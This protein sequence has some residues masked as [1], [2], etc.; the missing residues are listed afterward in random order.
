[1]T[2]ARTGLPREPRAQALRWWLRERRLPVVGWSLVALVIIAPLVAWRAGIFDPSPIAEP[3]TSFGTDGGNL[4]ERGA[5]GPSVEIGAVGSEGD[6]TRTFIIR[7]RGAT[8]RQPAVIFLHGFGSNIVAGYEPW[9]EHLAREGITVIFPSWQQP[10]FPTDGTQNPRNNM[11]EGVRQAVEAVPIQESKVAV[12]GMSAGGALA[13]DY[14]A[15]ATKL[16]GVP[17]ARLVYS[18]YPGRAFPGEKKIQLPLPPVGGIHPDAKIVNVVSRRDREAGIKAGV[19]QHN[20]VASR[21]ERLRTLTFITAPGLGGH[22][23]PGEAHRN[24][25][26]VFWNPFDKLLREHLGITLDRD[27]AVLD[28]A[29]EGN[30]AKKQVEDEALWRRR[31]IEGK[32]A[33]VPRPTSP[34]AAAAPAPVTP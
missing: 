34:S 30:I 27:Q 8:G 23:A 21:P 1:M 22:F 3:R 24:A 31:V 29:R 5:L 7:K 18:I 12:L 9:L 14:A 4:V 20:A 17:K 26:R 25:R 13:F 10:P 33:T 16:D 19:E 28:S 11:F 2:S 15:L 32:P 6:Q